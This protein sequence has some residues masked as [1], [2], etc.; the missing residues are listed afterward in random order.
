MKQRILSFVIAAVVACAPLGCS[1]G[2]SGRDSGQQALNGSDSGAALSG[3][4]EAKR[5]PDKGAVEK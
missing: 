4:E 1:R 5:K 3:E 2:D